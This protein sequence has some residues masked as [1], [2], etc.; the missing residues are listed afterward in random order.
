MVLLGI[1]V[2]LETSCEGKAQEGSGGRQEEP[3][4]ADTAERDA[5]SP[6]LELSDGGA[7]IREGG[8]EMSYS[9][10]GVLRVQKKM[11]Q[12]KMVVHFL[13]GE[14][15]VS[16][17]VVASMQSSTVSRPLLRETGTFRLELTGMILL[18]PM[19]D[20]AIDV[21]ESMSSATAAV[22]MYSIS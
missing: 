16:A 6:S 12:R 19:E 7:G 15:R 4:T 14:A 9:P 1:V 13:E 5:V 17:R 18:W 20:P 3:T 10:A 22:C 8:L 21:V 11:G 2:L